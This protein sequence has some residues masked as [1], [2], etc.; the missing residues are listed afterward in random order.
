MEHRTKCN[1]RSEGR[2]VQSRISIPVSSLAPVKLFKWR[3]VSQSD[4]IWL[5][6]CAVLTLLERVPHQEQGLARE[7]VAHSMILL[8]TENTGTIN[9]PKYFLF[10]ESGWRAPAG[11]ILCEAVLRPA[12]RVRSLNRDNSPQHRCNRRS[13]GNFWAEF[14]TQE[15]GGRI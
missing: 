10:L 3:A 9:P 7:P 12:V 1:A 5:W 2:R 6:C 4:P 13:T 8:A 15:E 14:C 11:C